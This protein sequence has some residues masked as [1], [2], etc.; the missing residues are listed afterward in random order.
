MSN[1]LAKEEI[2]LLEV[3]VTI[4][5][6]KFTIFIFIALSLIVAFIFQTYKGDSKTRALTEVRPISVID[7][8][9]YRI[10]TSVIK[11]L[12][13]FS[14]Q[15][16]IHVIEDKD[17]LLSNFQQRYENK[18]D[19]EINNI[20]KKFLLD[21]FV[22]KLSKKSNLINSIKKFELI[23]EDN[24][25]TKIEYEDEVTKIASAITLLNIDNIDYEK[26]SPVTIK[27][28]SFDIENWE[29]FLKFIEIETNFSIQENL[30]S[31]FSD[32]ITYLEAILKFQIEDLDTQ[33]LLTEN[34]TEIKELEKMK[35]TLLAEKYILR[36]KD[37][38][39]SS[40]ISKK[41]D[42]YAAK[43]I[44]DST[45]YEKIQKDSKIKTYFVFGM[46]GSLLGIIIV[47]I[48]NALQSR[49]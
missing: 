42:F 8:A 20:N 32:Y 12:N 43:I 13:P 11:N 44:Y 34:E 39:E 23:K 27:F 4:W 38:F 22:D 48:S 28:E 49:K 5:K 25:K 16:H 46:L 36:M 33:L 35:N 3:L 19:L 14:I 1:N 30:S 7:E 2:D 40:P 21:L 37:I 29:N 9:K 47:L 17:Q 18:I 15:D 31:M 41:E 45:K 10:Y 24:F 6:K 26:K